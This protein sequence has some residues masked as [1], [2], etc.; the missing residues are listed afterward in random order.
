MRNALLVVVLGLVAWSIA[1]AEQAAAQN[2]YAGYPGWWFGYGLAPSVYVRDPAPY[3]IVHPPVHYGWTTLKAVDPWAAQ[4]T[5]S[6]AAVSSTTTMVVMTPATLV[7]PYC[8][9]SIGSDGRKLAQAGKIVK[10][11]YVTN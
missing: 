5:Y 8:V 1:G 3:Y 4:R 10:N 11:P 6:D 7:N 2:P 9:G